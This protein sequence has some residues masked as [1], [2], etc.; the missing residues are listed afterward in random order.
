MTVRA[1]LFTHLTT[2]ESIYVF[3]VVLKGNAGR[4][5]EKPA[6]TQRVEM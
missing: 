6:V 2:S 3:R 4:K 1:K 5:S